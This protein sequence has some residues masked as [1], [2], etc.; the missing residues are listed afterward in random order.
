MDGTCVCESN[1]NCHSRPEIHLCDFSET[2]INDLSNVANIIAARDTAKQWKYNE[3]RRTYDARKEDQDTFQCN[4]VLVYCNG[5]L[6]EDGSR[7]ELAVIYYVGVSE[8]SLGIK[9]TH[10]TCFQVYYKT[11]SE[12]KTTRDRIQTSAYSGAQ[13]LAV[14]SLPDE[15]YIF[16]SN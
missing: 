3:Y 12:T 16:T 15:G 11:N 4:S 1:G 5:S 9:P 10:L 6:V 7:A 13:K 14:R 8:F 2:A